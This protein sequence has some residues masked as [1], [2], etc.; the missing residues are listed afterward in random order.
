MKWGTWARG[1]PSSTGASYTFPH[2]ALLDTV[3]SEE[4]GLWPPEYGT[5]VDSISLGR[6]KEG[7]GM[8]F[9]RTIYQKV[10]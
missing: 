6:L 10:G 9:A 7:R 1:H 8:D 2:Q 3:P 5:L 4:T